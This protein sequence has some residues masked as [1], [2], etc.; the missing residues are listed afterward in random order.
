MGSFGPYI[1]T[2][3]QDKGVDQ[4]VNDWNNN[5]PDDPPIT[6]EDYM[7]SRFNDLL[8]DYAKNIPLEKNWVKSVTDELVKSLATEDEVKLKEIEKVTGINRV[9]DDA[10]GQAVSDAG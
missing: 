3:R 7:A 9:K 1:T 8:N 4:V 10:N 5:H 6:A 2:G